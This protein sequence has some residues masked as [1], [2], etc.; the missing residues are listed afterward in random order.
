MK[1]CWKRERER[2]RNN[3]QTRDHRITGSMFE[4]DD[5]K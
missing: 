5:G 1:V 4:Q 3:K 2:G